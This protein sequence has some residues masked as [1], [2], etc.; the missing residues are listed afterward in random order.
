MESGPPGNRI[1]DLLTNSPI[2]D[3]LGNCA[4]LVSVVLTGGVCSQILALLVSP[5]G[6]T[7]LLGLL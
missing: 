7:T 2:H 4:L 6:M 3:S 5:E 1:P